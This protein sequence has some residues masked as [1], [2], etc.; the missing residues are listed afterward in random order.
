MS[1][2]QYIENNPDLKK[3]VHKLI[4]NEAR[5][6]TWIRWFVNP[7]VHKKERS[8][9]IRPHVRLDVLPFRGFT[10]GKESII[11]SYSVINNGVGDV[12]IGNNCTIGI[13]NVII[14]P[15]DI[16]SNVIIAQHVVISG[17]NHEYEDVDV[18]ICLQPIKT[19][20][21]T[22]EEDCWIG[23]NTVITAGITIGKHS[24]V[25]G[26]SIVTKNV[27][28]FSVVGGNPAKILKQYDFKNK[29]WNKPI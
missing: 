23:A 14:G 7:F 22:I 11:E 29:V 15:V 26:G 2:K 20:K 12:N 9:I 6:R 4:V 5:P 21:I 19:S 10:L 17:L 27:P 13:S 25:A 16:E 3:W 8:A 24:V 28:P 18:P 1:L